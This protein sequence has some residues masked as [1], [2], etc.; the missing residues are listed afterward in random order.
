MDFHLSNLS[1]TGNSGLDAEN[2]Y[3]MN[4]NST[5]NISKF[6]FLYTISAKAF[7]NQ[8]NNKIE[9][10]RINPD[11]M[12]Y[13]YVNINE[14]KTAGYGLD[15]SFNNH[16]RYSFTLSW[17]TTGLW[18]NFGNE[19]DS[20]DKYTWFTDISSTFNYTFPKQGV[21]LSM[22]YKFNG[23][24]PKYILENGTVGLFERGRYSMMDLSAAKSLFKN[25]F[26]VMAGVK[27]LLDVTDVKQ[28]FNGQDYVSLRGSNIIAYGRSFFLKIG[29][30]L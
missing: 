3:N 4:F 8:V 26:K 2:S 12:A 7:Y 23:K 17:T 14:I 19:Y 21:S 27:N 5:L 25:K 22:N 6:K 24:A 29:Y 20:P 13:T 9:L 18:N 30:V 11:Q 10:I 1:I 15:F 28:T 16:P